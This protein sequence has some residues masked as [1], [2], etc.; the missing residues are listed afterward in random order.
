MDP[1]GAPSR[2][3]VPLS[4]RCTGGKDFLLTWTARD[5]V[6][7]VRFVRDGDRLRIHDRWT[8]QADG[9]YDVSGEVVLDGDVR[10]GRSADGLI[11]ATM[12]W[13]RDGRS[14][15]S[16]STGVTFEAAR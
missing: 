14:Y 13:R 3:S 5:G 12:T 1:K 15:G 6:L 4:L 10:G 9:G 8:E 11:D 2:F 7:G 16:C